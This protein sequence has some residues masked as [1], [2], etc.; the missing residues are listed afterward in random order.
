MKGPPSRDTRGPRQLA[1]QRAHPARRGL[2]DPKGGRPPALAF[3][4]EVA[5][6]GIPWEGPAVLAKQ[7]PPAL[8]VPARGYDDPD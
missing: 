8:V 3:G 1:G 6:H 4:M 7:R 5:S 2:E